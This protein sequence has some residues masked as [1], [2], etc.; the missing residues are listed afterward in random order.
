M[1]SYIVNTLFPPLLVII[2]AKII[3]DTYTD[4]R[5]PGS[6]RIP[7]LSPFFSRHTEQKPKPSR[8]GCRRKEEFSEEIVERVAEAV[9]ERLHAE[10]SE[11]AN[12]RHCSIRIVCNIYGGRNIIAPNA[13][14]AVQNIRE[15]K[16]EDT[17]DP[18]FPLPD[19]D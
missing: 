7:Y 2:V 15:I 18:N 6:L 17:I 5:A 13:Q 3:S 1:V 4:N 12:T 8:T 10:R 19:E 9:L 11:C 16:E 14:T